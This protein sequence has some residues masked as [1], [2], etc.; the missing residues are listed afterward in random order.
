MY[1]GLENVSN[2]VRI[3]V[4]SNK[5][6]FGR[7]DDAMTEFLIACTAKSL[8]PDNIVSRA[9]KLEREFRAAEADGTLSSVASNLAIDVLEIHESLRLAI[10]EQRLK[11]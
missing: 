10:F 8:W 6:V 9:E 4:S 3:L 1:D 5:P 11:S 7:L 2:A